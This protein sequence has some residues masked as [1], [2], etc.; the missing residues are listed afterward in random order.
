MA[1][2]C[3]AGKVSWL[4][5]FALGVCVGG[6]QQQ[7][8]P[9]PALHAATASPGAPNSQTTNTSPATKIPPASGTLASPD[10]ANGPAP[11]TSPSGLANPEQGS[12]AGDASSAGPTQGSQNSTA[13]GASPAAAIPNNQQNLAAAP[14]APDVGAQVPPPGKASPSSGTSVALAGIPPV[15]MSAA[16][17]QGVKV[18]VGD[19]FPQVALPDG[20][21]Q[22]HTVADYQGKPTV[23]IMW[24]GNNPFAIEALKD[25]EPLILR[26]YGKV[27]LKVVA[28]NSFEK[29]ADQESLLGEWKPGFAMLWDTEQK[30]LTAVGGAEFPRIY[31]L[32]STGRV[33]WLDIEYSRSTR[34]QLQEALR[35]VVKEI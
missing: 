13:S 8:P 19:L 18:K 17:E 9:V 32:D 1:T 4:W 5:I 26:Q 10:Q 21:G 20:E 25:A 2:D 11:A 27:G 35:A 33:L 23:V 31:L 6:C 24:R 15:R 28:I 22:P 30:L 34:R 12:L 16:H 29:A 7:P 14:T 3:F